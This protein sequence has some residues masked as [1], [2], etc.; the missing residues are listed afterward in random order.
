MGIPQD[1]KEAVRWYRLAA[2]KGNS[3][4][5]FGLELMYEKEK[6]VPQDYKEAV[7]WYTL[8]A[9]KRKCSSA[10]QSRVLV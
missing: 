10:E 5:Q 6:G 3:I 1:Y 7:E 4:A 9:E 8:S 2:K